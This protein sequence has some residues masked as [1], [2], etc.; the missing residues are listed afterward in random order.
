MSQP[1]KRCC[2][3]SISKPY[4]E[5]VKGKNCVGG[6]RGLC[7]ECRNKESSKWRSEHKEE[8]VAMRNAWLEKNI[9]RRKEYERKRYI[10][11]KE[12]LNALGKIWR[13]N[14]LDKLRAK[15]ARRRAR[16]AGSG[17]SYSSEQISNLLVLQKCKCAMCKISLKNGM[18]H[19]HII[20]LAL[21]GSNN[22]E[23]IQLLCPTCNRRKNAKHPI[24]YAQELGLL[25]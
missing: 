22:I 17:G 23:N 14:N 12:R 8:M 18:E 19:D 4:S 13:E 9:E 25:L 7:K 20:S 10:E 16:R 3:C 21:G 11:N 5:L 6:V 2:R 15:E 24:D 1:E